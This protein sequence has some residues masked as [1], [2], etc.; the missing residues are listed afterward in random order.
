[1]LVLANTSH[2]KANAV[3]IGLTMVFQRLWQHLNIPDIIRMLIEKRN[4]TFDAECAVFLTMLHRLMRSGSDR[5]CDRWRRDYRVEGMD[6]LELHHSIG[7]WPGWA[8]RCPN[9][10]TPPPS[11]RAALKTYRR[12][13]VPATS[14]PVQKLEPGAVRRH[15]PLF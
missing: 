4:F 6:N 10:K 1:M 13:T 11:P 2:P 9:S 7:L 5:A 15:D 8:K 12:G 14:R 3:S